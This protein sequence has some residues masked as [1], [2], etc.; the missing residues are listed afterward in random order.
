LI[1][2]G[3]S[4]AIFSSTPASESEAAT[5]LRHLRNR[6]TETAATATFATDYEEGEYLLLRSAQRSDV[7]VVHALLM[8]ADPGSELIAKTVRGL[9]DHR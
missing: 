3:V 9:L 5:L 7:V 6:A 1:C 2:S 8:D 4:A